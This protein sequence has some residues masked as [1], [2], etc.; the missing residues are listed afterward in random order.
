MPDDEKRRLCHYIT[1]AHRYGKKVRLW[2]SPE[3]PVVW[4]E[5]LQ[6]GVDLINTDKLAKLK[7][8]LTNRS[9]LA[10]NVK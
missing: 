3:N 1:L 10:A 6:C 4:D 8:F 2:A 9:I 7:K 5:L